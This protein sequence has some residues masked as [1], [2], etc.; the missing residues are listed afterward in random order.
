MRLE[1]NDQVAKLSKWYENELAERLLISMG[2]PK[3]LTASKLKIFR[4]G[5][6]IVLIIILLTRLFVNGGGEFY[7]PLVF[8]AAVFSALSPTE[9]FP[10]IFTMF[11]APLFQRIHNYRVGRETAVFIQLLRNEV[12]EK[13]ERSVLSIIRQFQNY[14]KILQRDLLLLEHEWKNRKLALKNFAAQYPNNQEIDVIC[15]VLEKLEEIG[16]E[17]AAKSL[18]ENEDT[19]AE[20]QTASYKSRQKDINQVLTL[21]NISGVAAAALWGVL[22][23]FIWAYSFDINY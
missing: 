12:N 15:S 21:V 3:W 10:S 8:I 9:Q 2:A 19:L 17:A 6:C 14:F 11:V 16:Y 20:K 23:L 13:H 1:I 18:A 5:L 22:A 7:Y 4:D